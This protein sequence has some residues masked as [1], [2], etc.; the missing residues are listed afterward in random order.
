MC[1]GILINVNDNELDYA[2]STIIMIS[3]NSLLAST[4]VI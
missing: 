1:Q 4:A 2:K 3:F